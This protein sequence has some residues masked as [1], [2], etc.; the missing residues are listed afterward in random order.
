MPSPP[1][2][3]KGANCNAPG[4]PFLVSAAAPTRLSRR[5]RVWLSAVR[6]VCVIQ[7]SRTTTGHSW[8]T[9]SPPCTN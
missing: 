3:H 2:K 1:W 7:Q 4:D 8:W 9:P 6:S 5:P